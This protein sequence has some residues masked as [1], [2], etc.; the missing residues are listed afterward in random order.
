[1]RKIYLTAATLLSFII[2]GLTAYLVTHAPVSYT[3]ER[4]SKKVYVKKT[5]EKYTLIR[6]G[7]P[8]YVQGGAGYTHIDK[9]AAIGGN[10]IRT[11][12][13]TNLQGILDEAHRHNVAVIVGLDMLKSLHNDIFYADAD[14][15]SAQYDAF[16][17]VVKTYKDHPALL[18]WALGNELDFHLQPGYSEFYRTYKNLIKMIRETDPDHPI[19]TSFCSRG[20]QDF[21][22]FRV[23]NIDMDVICMNRFS[24][25]EHLSSE[26]ESDQWLWDKPII[27]TEWGPRGPWEK[28][29]T[30]WKAPIEEFDSAKAS[31]IEF[32]YHNHLPKEHPRFLGSLVFYWGQKQERTHT[33]F[34][35]FDEQG[36]TN[37]AVGKIQHLF[38]GE[39]PENTAPYVV[40]MTVNGKTAADNV[41]L[42]PGAVVESVVRAHDEDQDSLVYRWEILKE[43]WFFNDRE[44]SPKPEAVHGL[45]TSSEGTKINFTTPAESGPYRIFVHITDLRGHFATGNIPFYVMK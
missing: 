23:F 34:S 42:A 16:Q 39:Y 27:V 38:T 24:N 22:A 25:I 31:Q 35:L 8:F 41:V 5:G 32:V 10:T 45:I 19:T 13:T 9:L 15:V 12:D 29:S 6:N 17:H 7:E 26:L 2:L 20:R 37:Y 43:Q 40:E 21:A 11:W 30:S 36:N 28:A 44:I 14:K 33:W 18:M 4:T 1:M 3:G